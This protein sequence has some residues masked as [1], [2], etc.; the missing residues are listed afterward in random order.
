MGNNFLDTQYVQFLLVKMKVTDISGRFMKRLQ[1]SMH[2]IYAGMC[3]FLEY[4]NSN[5][6]LPDLTRRPTIAQ[7]K[8]YS[9]TRHARLQSVITN[10]K[11]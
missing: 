11:I 4:S 9:D 3:S 6:L 2:K 8:E 10:R 7:G 1:T 5:L